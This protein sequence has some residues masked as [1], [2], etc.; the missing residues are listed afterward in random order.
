MIIDHH[1]HLSYRLCTN[2]YPT[3]DDKIIAK[4][5]R[6]GIIIHAIGCAGIATASIA[7]LM[8]AHRQSQSITTYNITIEIT[9]QNPQHNVAMLLSM[10]ADYHIV[11]DNI[12]LHDPKISQH[13][14]SIMI[15]THG[16]N[17]AK[18]DLLRHA[19]KQHIAFH[20]IRI[21]YIA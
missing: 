18:F 6:S 8:E 4:S 11:I 16:T 14:G 7:S 2:C 9:T 3:P 12:Q 10:M 21:I 1:H 13:A 15:A 5:G 19:L 17:P 20:I